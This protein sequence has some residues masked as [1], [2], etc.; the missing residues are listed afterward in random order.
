MDTCRRYEYK[1]RNKDA[2]KKLDAALAV[3][4]VHAKVCCGADDVAWIGG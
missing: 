3:C 1:E 2:K 4:D